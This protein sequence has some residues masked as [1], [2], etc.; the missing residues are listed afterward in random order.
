MEKTYE[1]E[2]TF[3]SI[4]ILADTECGSNGAGC[5]QRGEREHGTAGGK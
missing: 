1:K 3:I 2:I 4:G 5:G